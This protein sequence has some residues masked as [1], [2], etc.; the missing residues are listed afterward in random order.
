MNPDNFIQKVFELGSNSSA[1]FEK[2]ALEVF[3]F[4][5][6]NCGVYKNFLQ[7]LSRDASAIKTLEQ[8]PFL[9][10]EFFKTQKVITENAEEEIV[11]T[12]SGTTGTEASRHFVVDSMIY[13]KSFLKGFELFYGHPED[14]CILALLPSYLEREGSSWFI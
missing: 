14:Y 7:F 3:R 9:P 8:I 13:E 11:F 2:L 1:E 6:E 10:I 4:Q 12:S 5:A